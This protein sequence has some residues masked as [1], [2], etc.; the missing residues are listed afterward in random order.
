M[1]INQ[2]RTGNINENPRKAYA[3]F[4]DLEKKYSVQDKIA[5]SN[6]PLTQDEIDE[7]SEPS[8]TQKEI[9]EILELPLT[10]EEIDKIS[11]PSLTQEEI[12][13]I[14]RNAIS[15]PSLTQEEV[16]EIIGHDQNEFS[17]EHH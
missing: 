7:I 9:D 17:W 2:K 1:A 5:V 13:E 8:L 3:L 16:D 6:I 14:L 15:E 12:D 11:E 4:S 10:Q